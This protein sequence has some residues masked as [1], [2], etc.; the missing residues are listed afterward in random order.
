[1]YRP[2]IIFIILAFFSF[3]KTSEKSSILIYLDKAADRI[4]IQ[5]FDSKIITDSQ[6]INNIITRFDILSIEPWIIGANEND[7]WEDICLNRIYRAVILN[8][9]GKSKLKEVKDE[10]LLIPG[11]FLVED[12]PVRRPLF[13]PNDPSFS[14]QC[15]INAVRASEAWDYWNPPSSS[16]GS[17]RVLVASVDSGVDYTHPDLQSNIWINQG[18]IPSFISELGDYDVNDD[19][20]I[21]ADE[22]LSAY[23]ELFNDD[24]NDDGSINLRDFVHESSPFVDGIDGDSNGYIDDLLGYDVSG[25]S[26]LDSDSDNDPYP[27]EGALANGNWAHG[28][29]VAGILGATTNNNLGISSVAF[30]VSVIPVKT[31]ADEEGETYGIIGGF[32]GLLYAAKAGFYSDSFTIVNCSWGG[33]GATAGEQATINVAHETYGAVIVAAAGN[34]KVD[35]NGFSDGEEYSE[36]YP[37]SYDN[38]LSVSAVNCNGLWGQWGTYNANVDLAAPGEDIYSTV[39]GSGYMNMDGS[40]M[41][42]PMASSA[43]ALLKSF[44]ADWTNNQLIERI[45][46]TADYETLYD[47]NPAYTDC[48]GNGSEGDNCLGQGIVDVKKA[49]AAYGVPNLSVSS[50]EVDDYSGDQD[51]VLNPGESAHVSLSLINEQGFGSVSSA[52]AILTCISDAVSISSSL[53]TFGQIEAG[54]LAKNEGSGFDLNIV[55]ESALQSLG[56]TVSIIALYGENQSYEVSMPLEISIS[57]NQF[58][59]PISLNSQVKGAP[60]IVDLDKDNKNEVFFADDYGNIYHLSV[61]EDSVYSRTALTFGSETSENQMW[62]SPSFSDLDG[63]G[64]NEVI[65]GSKNDTLYIINNDQ[66]V[67]RINTNFTLNTTS[68]IS[69]FID[70]SDL[71]VLSIGYQKG[72]KIILSSLSDE[73]T[74]LGLDVNEFSITSPAAFDFDLNGLRDIIFGTNSSNLYMINDQGNIFE[75]FPIMVSGQIKS[76][77]VVFTHLDETFIAFGSNDG[78]FYIF[79]STGSQLQKFDTGGKVD[80]SPAVLLFDDDLYVVFGS[81]DNLIYMYNK[82]GYSKDG[83]PVDA[84][85]DIVSIAVSDLDGDGLPDVVASSNNSLVHAFSIEGSYLPYFPIT[86]ENTPTGGITLHDVDGDQDLEIL[87]GTS[88]SLEAIDFKTQGTNDSYWFTDRANY[89]RTGFFNEKAGCTNESACNYDIQATVNDGS[90]LYLDCL[91]ECGGSSTIDSCG[92]CNGNNLSCGCTDSQAINYLETATNDDGSCLYSPSSFD[93]DLVNNASISQF[94]LEPGDE[95]YSFDF[96]WSS[97]S[98]PGQ[99]GDVESPDYYIAISKEVNFDGPVE[100]FGLPLSS[101]VVNE[102]VGSLL[103]STYSYQD[104]EPS[105]TDDVETYYWGVKVIDQKGLVGYCSSILSFTVDHTALSSSFYPLEFY[106]SQNYPN[107]FNPVTFFKYSIPSLGDVSIKVFDVRGKLVEVLVNKLHVEGQYTAKWDASSYPSGIYIIQMSSR[108]RS[109]SKKVILMK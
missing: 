23:I 13:T 35:E 91:D 74:V 39:I 93:L 17:K 70:D 78:S 57:L 67:T 79:D 46:E 11:I 85:G 89:N 107:P 44:Y 76:S 102:S 105:S 24:L 64:T 20:L 53:I 60:V 88:H 106:L 1:M 36:L 83:W 51:G 28:T 29:H 84:G 4:D 75:N 96:S 32:S 100:F 16:P 50:F 33:E 2:N 92:V 15:G 59:F 19:N 18:E 90:C 61:K 86:L 55:N 99:G 47:L 30:D 41:A 71:E 72:E 9:L 38:V 42:S 94:I 27:R 109:L 58:G 34:G 31:A 43:I 82:N 10:L 45:L 22:L 80:T 7:C 65:F 5:K 101:F 54:E 95:N 56:C 26:I 104:L 14:S 97:S 40:S 81:D 63:N 87:V 77:P 73:S 103:E 69:N 48:K 6:Q 21:D 3:L 62:G 52:Q 37:A 8:N 12:E 25:F 68:V 108:K 66:S 49:I 98:Y